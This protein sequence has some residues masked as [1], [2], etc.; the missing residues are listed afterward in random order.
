MSEN[1][2]PGIENPTPEDYLGLALAEQ[3]LNL[4]FGIRDLRTQR[5]LTPE[6]VAEAIGID[7]DSL[8]RLEMGGTNPTMSTIR[9]YAK[10]CGAHFRIN[11]TRWDSTQS[12]KEDT[13]V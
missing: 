11:V 9:R 10:A 5:G 13:D 7:L 12:E 2:F 6:Q 3:Q 8:W 1:K 4:V